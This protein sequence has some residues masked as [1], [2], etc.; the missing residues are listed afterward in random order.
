M[1]LP[2]V[3]I[4]LYNP[5]HFDGQ[6]QRLYVSIRGQVAMKEFQQPVAFGVE[7]LNN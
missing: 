5:I 1:Q 2:N 3:E 4:L 6:N 7:V